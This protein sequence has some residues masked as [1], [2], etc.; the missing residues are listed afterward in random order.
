MPSRIGIEPVFHNESVIWSGV[1]LT[2]R[3][4]RTFINIF[5]TTMWPFFRIPYK[6]CALLALC[7]IENIANR[8]KNFMKIKS[9]IITIYLNSCLLST[10]FLWNETL[11]TISI[12]LTNIYFH[13]LFYF[14]TREAFSIIII[15]FW[16]GFIS[17][18]IF[19]NDDYY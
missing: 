18:G 2:I 4:Q 14:F 16:L 9:N 8:K 13:F 5:S 1:L 15:N 19:I 3:L 11:S 17:L 12:H 6:T 10:S 7:Q